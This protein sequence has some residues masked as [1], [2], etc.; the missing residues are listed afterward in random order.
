MYIAANSLER[1]YFAICLF[2]LYF[3]ISDAGIRKILLP[4]DEGLQSPEIIPVFA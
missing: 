2:W 3:L 1:D 4:A